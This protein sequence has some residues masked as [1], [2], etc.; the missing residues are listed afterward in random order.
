MRKKRTHRQTETQRF[1]ENNMCANVTNAYHNSNSDKHIQRNIHADIIAGRQTK[2]DTD[3]QRDIHTK[4][5]RQIDRQTERQVGNAMR[6]TE[7]RQT[8][9]KPKDRQR[10]IGR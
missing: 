7:R 2:Q 10:Q 4:T 5:E 6:K 9:S 3:R 8:D 1:N